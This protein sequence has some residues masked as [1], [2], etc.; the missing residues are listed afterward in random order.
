[1]G[2]M[3]KMKAANGLNFGRIE[4]P[5]FPCGKIVMKEGKPWI[6]NGAMN[7]PNFDRPI[8][9]SDIRVF[10][11][12][13]CGGEWAKYLLVFKDGKSGVITQ[14]V[15]SDN[16]MRAKGSGVN[17]APIERLFKFVDDTPTMVVASGGVSSASAPAEPVIQKKVCPK[18]GADIDDEMLFCAEC[19]EKLK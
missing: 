13:G 12:I 7:G 5:D 15:L 4:S 14:D 6:I 9:Q 10:K 19:G 11:L 18:C 16:Q 8:I 3:D 1:M 17:M 2:F